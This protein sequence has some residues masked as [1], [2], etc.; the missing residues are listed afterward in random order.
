MPQ[1]REHKV[2]TPVCVCVCVLPCLLKGQEG[3]G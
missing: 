1:D 3:A 2:V